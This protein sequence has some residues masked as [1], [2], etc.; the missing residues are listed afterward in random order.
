MCCC[1]ENSTDTSNVSHLE[2][3]SFF[4]PGS[5]SRM[6]TTLLALNAV[7]TWAKMLKYLSAFPYIGMLSITLAHAYY[8]TLCFLILFFNLFV[9]WSMAF[10]MAFGGHMLQYSTVPE[11]MMSLFRMILGDYEFDDMYAVDRLAAMVLFVVYIIV[12]MFLLSNMFVAMLSNSYNVAKTRVMGDEMTEQNKDKW[13]GAESFMAYMWR[14]LTDYRACKPCKTVKVDAVNEQNKQDAMDA[15]VLW[16]GG[17]PAGAS[18]EGLERLLGRYGHP[19]VFLR[20]KEGERASWALASFKSTSE[21]AACVGAANPAPGEHGLVLPG[22]VLPA[23]ESTDGHDV[24]LKVQ[25]SSEGQVAKQLLANPE[26]GLADAW[27]EMQMAGAVNTDKRK[28]TWSPYEQTAM[29]NVMVRGET[30]KMWELLE[31]TRETDRFLGGPMFRQTLDALETKDGFHGLIP[32][33]QYLKLSLA[34]ANVEARKKFAAAGLAVMSL[35]KVK[36]YQRTPREDLEDVVEAS[37]GV[38]F[39]TRHRMK[40]F[41][42][43]HLKKRSSQ[44]VAL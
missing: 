41:G 2:H 27:F 5:L 15:A 12:A 31:A 7:L 10:S 37:G 36:G 30:K 33:A 8:E 28:S 38:V 20:E 14:M 21:A 18:Q 29:V 25:W 13:G 17:I 34:P 1:A 24:E 3:I 23:L 44:P 6:A 22:L 11:A 40:T 26:G 16:I 32:E 19:K 39:E 43:Q 35:G 4:L 42:G 9:G